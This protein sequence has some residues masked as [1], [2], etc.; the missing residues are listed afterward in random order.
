MGATL[1]WDPGLFFCCSPT[2]MRADLSLTNETSFVFY[3]YR[4]GVSRSCSVKCSVA[5]LICVHVVILGRV[6]TVTWCLWV[7]ARL[8]GR[9]RSESGAQRCLRSRDLGKAQAKFRTFQGHQKTGQA[10]IIEDKSC[11]LLVFAG[12]RI[13][14]PTNTTEQYIRTQHLKHTHTEHYNSPVFNM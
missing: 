14:P 7:N 6:K 10:E 4:V 9:H 3:S 2:L 5:Q 13:H 11:A 12:T 1:I 8:P